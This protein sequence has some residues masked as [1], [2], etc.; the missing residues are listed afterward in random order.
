M[1]QY[2]AAKSTA[3]R[4]GT[5]LMLDLS[6]YDQTTF[7]CGR[8]FSLSCFELTDSIVSTRDVLKL[9]PW[10]A[11]VDCLKG[12][13]SIL[14]RR[15]LFSFIETVFFK[16]GCIPKGGKLIED[17][18]RGDLLAPIPLSRVYLQRAPYYTDDFECIPDNV[19]ML[20]HWESEK[21]FCEFTREIRDIFRFNPH[22]MTNSPLFPKIM[23]GQSVSLHIRRTD[24]LI[25]QGFLSTD[26]G[27]ISRAIQIIEAKIVAPCFFVFSDD[28]EWC[29]AV[30]PTLT[31]APVCFVEGTGNDDAYKDMLLMSLCDHNVIGTSTFSWWGAW[32]NKNDKKIV[33]APHEKLWYTEAETRFDILP[34]DWIILQ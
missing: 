29:K 3:M 11:L 4:L 27:Y 9:Y 7:S 18:V 33:I 17:M 6:W 15:K 22:S 34:K 2:A 10:R 25:D 16:W 28:I 24:K 31:G 30:I 26:T 8:H 14:L 32:L 19:Y 21:F 5:Q 12:D 1:F 23:G 13:S 20:G